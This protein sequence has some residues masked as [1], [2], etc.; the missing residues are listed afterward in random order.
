MDALFTEIHA[1]LGEG[2][3]DDLTLLL[4][5]REGGEED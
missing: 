1:Y 2:D 4:I 5:H 3:H